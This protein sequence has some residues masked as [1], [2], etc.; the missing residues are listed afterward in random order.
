[1]AV[2]L[3]VA[4]VVDVFV[5]IPSAVDVADPRIDELTG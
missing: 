3:A 1:M 2:G 4:L 5:A